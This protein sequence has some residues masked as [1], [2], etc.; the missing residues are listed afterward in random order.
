MQASFPHHQLGHQS[1]ILNIS[2]DNQPINSWSSSFY[3]GTTLLIWKV[4]FTL[5]QTSLHVISTHVSWINA[6]LSLVPLIHTDLHISE[7]SCRYSL[8]LC[9][10]KS[11][12]ILFSDSPC[13]MSL[14]LSSNLNLPVIVWKFPIFEF[15]SQNI[16]T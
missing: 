8:H 3:L 9:C 13:I 2:S 11:I 1:R 7:N 10:R 6:K 15:L 5:N 14:R 16:R 12:S 4:F